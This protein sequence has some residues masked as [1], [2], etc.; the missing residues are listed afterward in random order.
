M[1][2]LKK[3]MAALALTA[4]LAGCSGGGVLSSLKGGSTSAQSISRPAAVSYTHLT[5][6]TKLEV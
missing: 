1:R 4:V 2:A 5:L 6:P 3:I